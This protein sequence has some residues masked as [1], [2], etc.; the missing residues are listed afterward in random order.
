MPRPQKAKS[1]LPARV[2]S[3]ST[4][5]LEAEIKALRRELH[6]VREMV[7]ELLHRHGNQCAGARGGKLLWDRERRI[8]LEEAAKLVWG[9]SVAKEAESLRIHAEILK[10]WAAKGLNGNVLESNVSRGK[11]YTSQEAVNR[12]LDQSGF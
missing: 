10:S 5:S 1:S 4:N 12:F 7:V 11:W 9:K 8:S 3:V 2:P 6:E